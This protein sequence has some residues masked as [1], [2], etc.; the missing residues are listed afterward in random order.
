M[1]SQVMPPFIIGNR[2]SQ[3]KYNDKQIK[4]KCQSNIYFFTGARV[5][6]VNGLL[7]IGLGL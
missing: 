7:F 3:W 2:L 6:F 5:A 1:P 4:Y